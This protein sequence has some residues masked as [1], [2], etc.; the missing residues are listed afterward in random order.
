MQ[1]L[2]Q[3]SKIQLQRIS[4]FSSDLRINSQLSVSIVNDRRDK[5]WKRKISQ[6]GL[7]TLTLTLDQDKWHITMQYSLAHKISFESDYPQKA[8]GICR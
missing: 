4:V 5:F 8:T 1:Q 2:D 3:K 7:M 6:F